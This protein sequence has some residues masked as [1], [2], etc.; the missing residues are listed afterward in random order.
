MRNGLPATGGRGDNAFYISGAV[1]RRSCSRRFFGAFRALLLFK[2]VNM[3]KYLVALALVVVLGGSVV[4]ARG[5]GGGGGGRGGGGGGGGPGGGFGGGGPG[6][7]GGGGPGGGGGGFG[8]GRGGFGF[9]NPNPSAT[10]TAQ[11]TDLTDDQKTK[12]A[13]ASAALD[14]T[15]TA[16][17]TSSG[18]VLTPLTPAAGAAPDP[19]AQKKLADETYKQNLLREDILIDGEL[20]MLAILTPAQ[21]IK[22]ETFRLTQ[23]ANGRFGTLGLTDD[24]LAKRDALIKEYAAKLV[25]LKDKAAYTKMKVE[26]WTKTLGFLND[27]QIGQIFV[28]TFPGRGFGGGGGGAFGGGGGGFGGG[29]GGGAGGAGGGGFGGGGGRGAGGGGR[30]GRG[31]GAGGGGAGGA[32]G[33]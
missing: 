20:K 23:Q 25:V 10:I 2:G 21:Q 4:Y 11:I 1:V 18:A 16:W 15:L 7:G 12:L 27:P 5:G 9:A 8:G 24:Q 26:F 19:A 13:A 31:G 30:G 14:E 3:K 32:G 17:Q 29:R 28:P 33:G 22:W 6:G